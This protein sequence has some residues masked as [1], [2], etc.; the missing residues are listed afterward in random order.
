MLLKALTI[1]KFILTLFLATLGFAA[2]KMFEISYTL[3]VFF[4][5]LI[6]LL[7]PGAWFKLGII[8]S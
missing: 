1:F 4:L 7:G 6:L 2:G 3:F 8:Y 5:H